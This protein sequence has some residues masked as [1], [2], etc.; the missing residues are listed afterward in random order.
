M[1]TKPNDLQTIKTRDD[2]GP[3]HLHRIPGDGLDAKFSVDQTKHCSWAKS[4][5]QI[6]PDILR[7]R[8]EP[9]LTSLVQSEHLSLLVGSGLTHA[10]HWLAKGENLPG[11]VPR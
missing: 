7:P 4:N 2:R 9:W 11:I 6:G 8:I 1:A 5:D 3:V 10:V